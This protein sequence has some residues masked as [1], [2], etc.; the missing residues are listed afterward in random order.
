VLVGLAAFVVAG[1]GVIWWRVSQNTP[2]VSQRSPTVY[3]YKG[4]IWPVFA[5]AWSPNGQRIASA[6][7]DNTV[8]V[9]NAADGGHVYTYKG[10]TDAVDAVAWSPNG[11]R[12]ASGSNDN[13]V[14]VWQ[15]VSG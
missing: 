7:S 11:Q 6:S 10:H 12:I 9:W 15:E 13:T 3:T 2:P 4:H 1:G 8:Q 5:V 14:Q